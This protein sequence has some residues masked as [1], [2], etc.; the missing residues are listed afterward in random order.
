MVREGGEVPGCGIIGVV[1][2][3][4]EAVTF[5]V[6]VAVFDHTQFWVLMRNSLKSSCE[7]SVKTRL[8][9]IIAESMV[10]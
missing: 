9:F 5:P 3:E 6:V 4:D 1:I 2:A 7:P 8:P 10:L